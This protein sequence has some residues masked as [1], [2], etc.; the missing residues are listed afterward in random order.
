MGE[1]IDSLG[2]VINFST[3]DDNSGYWQIEI[4]D[5]DEDKTAFTSHHG[6]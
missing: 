4:D 3:L 6:V 2:E 1:Y 5:V